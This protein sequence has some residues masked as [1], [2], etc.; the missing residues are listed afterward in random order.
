MRRRWKYFSIE[1]VVP[2]LLQGAGLRAAISF[3]CQRF[4]NIPPPHAMMKMADPTFIM[5]L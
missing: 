5:G 3:A 4:R 2:S 1:V